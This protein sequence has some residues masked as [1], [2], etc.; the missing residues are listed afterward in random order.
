MKH[1]IV[2]EITHEELSGTELN[3]LEMDLLGQL[4]DSSE[5]GE[6]EE[7]TYKIVDQS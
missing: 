2:I 1:T 5:C 4:E 6:Y 3:Q 7:F